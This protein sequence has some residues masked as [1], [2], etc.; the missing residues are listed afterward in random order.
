MRSNLR[1]A[2][3]AIVCLCASTRLD[4]AV[5]C[6]KD[7]PA[8]NAAMTI[9]QSNGEDDVIQM[10]AGVFTPSAP[11]FMYQSDEAHSLTIA[12]GYFTLPEMAACAYQ[13]PGAGFTIIDGGASKAALYID[14]TAAE[15]SISV[16]NLTVRNAL[17]SSLVPALR[18]VGAG[19]VTLD[20]VVVRASQADS[21]VAQI[22]S[23]NS[24]A[25][26]RNCA[27][28]DN[29]SLAPDAKA[30]LVS[31]NAGVTPAVV[32]D[33]N[34]VAGN[35][36]MAGALLGGSGDMTIANNVLW[37]NGGTDLILAGN[38]NAELSSNDYGTRSGSSNSDVD[39]MHVDPGFI[40]PGDFR[41]RSDSPLR[42]AGDNA[43]IGGIGSWDAE[44]G[45]RVVYGVVDRGA[46]EVSDIIFAYGC[47]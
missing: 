46:Y 17:S 42:D 1:A 3:A 35:L 24:Q 13:L 27:F 4:A 28:V 26:V 45:E 41:L 32:F 5:F 10:Q 23:T 12:G 40:A 39:A 21:Y 8:L 19:A 37:N 30:V 11:S 22:S 25:Q 6:V 7:T 29:A 36:G 47:D 34:T 43:A 33:N 9:A 15:S 16:S 18:L 44:G 31:A 2:F 14:A 38:G 20:N